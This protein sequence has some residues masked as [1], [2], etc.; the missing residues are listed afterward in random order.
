MDAD[1]DFINDDITFFRKE[2]SQIK[3]DSDFAFWALLFNVGM[4]TSRWWVIVVTHK[5]WNLEPTSNYYQN[6]KYL[7]AYYLSEIGVFKIIDFF[8][9]N[10][11]MATVSFSSTNIS[12]IFQRRLIFKRCL[13][14]INGLYCGITILGFSVDCS[15][16]E[17][18]I[19]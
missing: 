2:R 9:G 10:S 6:E 7:W 12:L 19:L 4:M 3:R 5:F 11:D 14:I 13:I 8:S 15:C 17:N 1:Y 16:M 18:F